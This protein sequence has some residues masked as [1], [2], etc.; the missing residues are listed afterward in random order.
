MGF[1]QVLAIPAS[2]LDL[3]QVGTNLL[4]IMPAKGCPSCA[5]K[6]FV[7][8]ANTS[9]FVQNTVLREQGKSH[10]VLVLRACHPSS[11]AFDKAPTSRSEQN[12]VA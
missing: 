1:V 7:L 8:C 3:L 4:C 2:V 9:S 12:S 5:L 11:V 6:Y 10:S